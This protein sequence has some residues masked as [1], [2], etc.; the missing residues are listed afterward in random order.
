MRFYLGLRTTD[1]PLFQIEKALALP[2]TQDRI[3]DDK[4]EDWIAAT[5]GWSS[6]VAKVNE[7]SYTSS[8]GEY[9]PGGG[10]ELVA[11]YLELARGET[12]LARDS[13]KTMIELLKI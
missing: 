13:L 1:H 5:E 11:K 7:L 6:H 12:V 10:K 9:N 4:F 8:F 2:A 3:E